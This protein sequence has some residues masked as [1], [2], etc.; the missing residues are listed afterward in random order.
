MSGLGSVLE[1]GSYVI[2]RFHL[3]CSRGGDQKGQ[4]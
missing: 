4:Q 1:L 3:K 2:H